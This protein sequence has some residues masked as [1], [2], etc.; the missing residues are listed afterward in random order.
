MQNIYILLLSCE[1][2]QSEA[3]KL[4]GILKTKIILVYKIAFILLLF[5]KVTEGRLRCR[6]GMIRSAVFNF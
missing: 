6:E 1:N 5:S 3:K 2:V 4:N